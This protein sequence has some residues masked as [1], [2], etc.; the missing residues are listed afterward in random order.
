MLQLT[1]DLSSSLC[2]HLQHADVVEVARPLQRQNKK[3][4]TCATAFKEK[5]TKPQNKL[6]TF[7]EEVKQ[8]VHA[9]EVHGVKK[10]DQEKQQDV[11]SMLNQLCR[12]LMGQRIAGQWERQDHFEGALRLAL[13]LATAAKIYLATSTHTMYS[14]QSPSNNCCL[15]RPE[16]TR[17]RIF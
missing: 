5:A 7:R 11:E 14:N 17:R 15:C 6:S 12:D 9:L 3:V 10:I 8:V 1:T 16:M 13:F 4:K 2:M